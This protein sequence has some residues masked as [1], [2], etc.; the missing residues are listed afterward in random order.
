M[1]ECEDSEGVGIV[2]QNYMIYSL[3]AAGGVADM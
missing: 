2:T 3:A 1:S